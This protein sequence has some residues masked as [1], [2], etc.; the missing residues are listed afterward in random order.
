MSST[1]DL[2][3][4]ISSTIRAEKARH[5]VT[6]EALSKRLKALGVHQSATNL[7]TKV[8]RGNLSAPLFIAILLALDHPVIDLSKAFKAPAQN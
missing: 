2:R 7:S 8:A 3:S 6:Y 1:A 4:F 5:N